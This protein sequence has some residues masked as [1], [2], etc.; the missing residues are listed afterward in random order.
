[1][2]PGTETLFCMYVRAGRS[3]Y[4]AL[5]WMNGVNR[6]SV[7]LVVPM[8]MALAR[9]LMTAMTRSMRSSMDT[10][11]LTPLFRGALEV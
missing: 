2:L 6:G 5:N 7:S 9:V 4:R 1:M 11:L 3:L 10:P 8:A